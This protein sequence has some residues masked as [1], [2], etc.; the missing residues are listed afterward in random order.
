VREDAGDDEKYDHS[1]PVH[2]SF[3]IPIMTASSLST[4]T[5]DMQASIDMEVQQVGPKCDDCKELKMLS[6]TVRLHDHN[7]AYRADGKHARQLTNM[8]S[9]DVI[10]EAESGN[11]QPDD[12]GRDRAAA[13]RINFLA[14]DRSDLRYA[15]RNVSQHMAVPVRTTTSSSRTLAST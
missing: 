2:A 14:V 5:T 12:R 10:K 3:T 8:V 11:E 7:M 6:R 15:A 9:S 1:R 13:A 4:V